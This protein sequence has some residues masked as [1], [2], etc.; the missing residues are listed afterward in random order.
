MQ[1]L[2]VWILTIQ[3]VG[4]D[5]VLEAASSERNARNML[6]QYV[7]DNWDEEWIDIDHA[8]FTHTQHQIDYYVENK[9]MEYDI[10]KRWVDID[11]KT[12]VSF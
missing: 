9:E 4:C 7:V 1:P 5:L 8:N 3:E 2:E 6:W 11:S 10:V 12:Y